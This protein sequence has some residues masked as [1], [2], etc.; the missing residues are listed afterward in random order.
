[1]Q[2]FPNG[3]VATPPNVVNGQ[4]IPPGGSGGWG[5]NRAPGVN[6]TPADADTLNDILGNLLRVLQAAG[7]TPTPNRYDDLLQALTALYTPVNA[8]WNATSGPA[9]ILN[10]P[11]LDIAVCPSLVVEFGNNGQSNGGRGIDQGNWYQLNF[12]IGANSYNGFPFTPNPD[13]TAQLEEGGVYLVCCNAKIISSNSDAY[14]IPVQMAVATGQAYAYPGIYQYAVQK[15]PDPPVG[16]QSV[17]GVVGN[18]SFSGVIASWGAGP[19][20]LGFSKV[21]GASGAALSLQGTIS[22]TK[23]G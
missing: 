11:A 19:L 8:D 6:G 9:K 15:F 5:Q 12:N 3:G 20:W 13:G 1:M 23:I 17:S 14:P 7:V 18:V 2:L 4:P 21:V 16:N 10:K 22:Y